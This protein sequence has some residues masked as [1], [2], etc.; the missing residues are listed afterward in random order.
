MGCVVTLLALARRPWLLH[1]ATLLVGSRRG[2]QGTT[3]EPFNSTPMAV[4]SISPG[5]PHVHSMRRT[6][7]EPDGIKKN[8]H[9][10]KETITALSRCQGFN[11]ALANLLTPGKKPHGKKGKLPYAPRAGQYHPRGGRFDFGWPPAR[12]M[13]PRGGARV[14][15]EPNEIK[16]NAPPKHATIVLRR[17]GGAD[18]AR[19]R[20]KARAPAGKGAATMRLLEVHSKVSPSA[21]NRFAE[22][23]L[24]YTTA[25]CHVKKGYSNTDGVNNVLSANRFAAKRSRW[26]PRPRRTKAAA[27]AAAAM[28]KVGRAPGGSLGGVP[29]SVPA[30]RRR[31]TTSQATPATTVTRNS[32]SVTQRGALPFDSAKRPYPRAHTMRA[33]RPRNVACRL[34]QRQ[35]YANGIE[36]AGRHS[37]YYEL[38]VCCRGLCTVLLH[39][40]TVLLH[41]TVTL[42]HCYTVLLHCYTARASC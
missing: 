23:P 9:H 30:R 27:A 42:L 35:G 29:C 15:G 26:W 3:R 19:P 36:L 7:G 24:L 39:C 14:C 8:T 37:Y 11:T 31:T 4:N 34:R 28:G 21:A 22:A 17:A 33:H 5:S 18:K 41:C 32:G 40:Y 16:Q 20:T 12:A 6:C 13:H 25:N 38:F 1:R 2:R 10:E